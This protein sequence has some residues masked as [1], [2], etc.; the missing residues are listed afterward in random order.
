M[1]M[2]VTG[3]RYLVFL[4]TD[5]YEY[6]AW[7]ARRK[8]DLALAER[9]YRRAVGLYQEELPVDHPYR[10][11]AEDGLGEMIGGAP[12]SGSCAGARSP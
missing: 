8:G 11:R 12:T 9:L 7:A 10:R 1:A 2:C 5:G 6:L 4:I 3:W